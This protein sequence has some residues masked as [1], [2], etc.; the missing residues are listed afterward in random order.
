MA[1]KTSD[2]IIADLNTILGD[3]NSDDALQL[4][5]DIRDTLGSQ[6]DAQRISELE[7]QLQEQDANWR[8]KYREA[9]LSGGDES[10]EEESKTPRRFEDLF[11]TK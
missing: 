4:L 5:T 8:R 6:T 10:Y 2:E 11:E 1:I 7:A 3:N 9:F